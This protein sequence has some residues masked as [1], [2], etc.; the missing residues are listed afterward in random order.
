MA[1]YPISPDT[2]TSLY[3]EA[4]T[5]SST[6]TSE[7]ATGDLAG[8]TFTLQDGSEFPL[9]NFLAVIDNEIILIAS[10]S[11]NTLTIGARAMEG[12]T[13]A[14][15]PVGALCGNPYTAGSRQLTKQAS[16]DHQNYLFN[17]KGRIINRTVTDDTTLTPV[18]YDQ[19]IVATGAINGFLGQDGKLAYYDGL[20]W[21]FI[22]P[23]KGDRTYNLDTE[24]ILRHDGTNWLVD[25]STPHYDS[26]IDW[27][28]DQVFLQSD[29]LWRTVAPVPAGT[30]FDPE[31]SALFAQLTFSAPPI[32]SVL[33]APDFTTQDP[34]AVDTP[35]QITFGPAQFG[36]T[37]PVQLSTAGATTFNES[38]SYEVS[39]NF[40]ANRSS[41]ANVSYMWIRGLLNGVA[42]GDPVTA[43]SSESD[44]TLP[45]AFTRSGQYAVGDVLTF[46]FYRD[47]I[48]VDNGVLS[49]ESSSIGWGQSPSAK[50]SI[51]KIG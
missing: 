4:N 2:Q 48:G 22:A 1:Q 33:D 39:A 25:E 51:K 41:A 16:I 18:K 6:L 42:V 35:I 10:R 31:N 5:A 44:I 36:P 30:P 45:L 49:P 24:Q 23:V 50:L 21:G 43:R 20:T 27:A 7:I 14:T 17:Y 37:D 47:S 40:A 29:E 11:A 46:E 28:V 8:A 12:T 34:G 13:A 32:V 3:E 26:T 9:N 19:Y 15:H 38:G